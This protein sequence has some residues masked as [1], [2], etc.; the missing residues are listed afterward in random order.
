MSKAVKTGETTIG[1]AAEQLTTV[2][3]EF[4]RTQGSFDTPRDVSPVGEGVE[5]TAP[6]PG[7]EAEQPAGDAGDVQPDER[8]GRPGL[9][10]TGEAGD[11]GG[12]RERGGAPALTTEREEGTAVGARN[13]VLIDGQHVGVV[14][15]SSGTAGREGA[16]VYYP[17]DE[18]SRVESLAVL[19]PDLEEATNIVKATLEQEGGGAEPEPDATLDLFQDGA[20]V[21]LNDKL[22]DERTPGCDTRA[23]RSST[24]RARP[25]GIQS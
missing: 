23:C 15:R 16:Y 10:E 19:P 24:P 8:G 11:E 25:T 6:V 12:D 4:I 14:E 21:A 20:P 13:H 7:Q 18:E 3:V 17:D 22:A 5:P 1:K 9:T 2:V